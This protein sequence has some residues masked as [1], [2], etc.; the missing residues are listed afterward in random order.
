MSV[1]RLVR[2]R[3]T[4]A[5]RA[6]ETRGIWLRTDASA[7]NT[8]VIVPAISANSCDAP[9]DSSAHDPAYGAQR[10]RRCGRTATAVP[11]PVARMP[12]G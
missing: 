9:P 7:T 3:S 8:T 2:A 10:R 12:V 5:A 4:P 11:T 6:L 1:P